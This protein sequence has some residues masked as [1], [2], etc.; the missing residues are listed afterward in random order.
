MDKQKKQ[1]FIIN[2]LIVIIKSRNT[3]MQ[4][5]LQNTLDSFQMQINPFEIPKQETL[6]RPL[7][8]SD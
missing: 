5:Y 2:I 1:F 4:S 6:K 8:I 7:C 3:E